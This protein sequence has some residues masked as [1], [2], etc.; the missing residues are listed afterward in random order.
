MLLRAGTALSSNFQ[1]CLILEDKEPLVKQCP[2]FFV[3]S[4]TKAGSEQFGEMAARAQSTNL[5]HKISLLDQAE[6]QNRSA[7]NFVWLKENKAAV[8]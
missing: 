2:L 4:K 1:T 8:R 3:L 7:M 6:V 5:S